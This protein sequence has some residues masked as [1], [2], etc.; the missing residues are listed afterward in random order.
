MPRPATE[1]VLMLPLVG[2]VELEII[3]VKS[4]CLLKS[5]IWYKTK[6]YFHSFACGHRVFIALRKRVDAS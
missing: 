5:F 4:L 6:A 1:S 2:R 3:V